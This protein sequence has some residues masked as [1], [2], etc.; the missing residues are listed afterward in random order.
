MKVKR[1]KSS[2]FGKTVRAALAGCIA[3]IAISLLLAAACAALIDRG[4]VSVQNESML[5]CIVQSAAFFAGTWLSCS[6]AK[7][8]KLL[9]AGITVGGSLFVLLGVVITVWE[10]EFGQVLWGV[11]LCLA[12]GAAGL[13]L[14]NLPRRKKSPVRVKYR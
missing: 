6:I 13:L 10:G 11:F 8:K 4:V 12:A 2:V 3:V 14:H 9:T 5:A 7:D 1:N